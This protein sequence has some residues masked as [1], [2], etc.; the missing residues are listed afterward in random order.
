MGVNRA[1]V[2]KFG[3]RGRG[4]TKYNTQRLLSESYEAEILDAQVYSDLKDE[5]NLAWF[6]DEYNATTAAIDLDLAAPDAKLYE[7]GILYDT[8]PEETAADPFPGIEVDRDW[9]MV[10]LAPTDGEGEWDV[11]SIMSM[12][13][14]ADADD[15]DGRSVA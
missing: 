5:P 14:D 1:Y 9:E 13:D 11:V 2:S 15:W 7:M 10:P 3:R 4:V 12:E 6:Y 8:P